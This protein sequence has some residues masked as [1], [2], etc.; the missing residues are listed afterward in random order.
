MTQSGFDLHKQ[1]RFF[2]YI[3]YLLIH[4]IVKLVKK[5]YLIIIILFQEFLIAELSSDVIMCFFKN[6]VYNCC[7]A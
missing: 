4:V 7:V 5:C 3:L 2:R 6:V 1:M